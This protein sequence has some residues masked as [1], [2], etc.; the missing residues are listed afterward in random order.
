MNIQADAQALRYSSL[1]LHELS[2]D[3]ARLI[4][5]MEEVTRQLNKQT[6]L[7]ASNRLLEQAVQ[8][9]GTQRYRLGVL[10]QALD[11]IAGMYGGVEERVGDLFTE[12]CQPQ[13]NADPLQFPDFAGTSSRLS[14]LLYGG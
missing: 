9:I 10:S 3:L 7:K 6:P 13:S 5:E 11:N 1:E 2:L 4:P 12:V 14:T 8:E